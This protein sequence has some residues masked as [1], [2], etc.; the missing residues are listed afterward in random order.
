MAPDEAA[1]PIPDVA[2]LVDEMA[3][4]AIAADASA[5]IRC[6][7]P[8]AAAIIGAPAGDVIG[9][10]LVTLVPERFRAVH[11]PAFDRFAATGEGTIVGGPPVRVFL[12]RADGTEV[13]V[14]LALTAVGEPGRAGFAVV[15]AMRDVPGP[16]DLAPRPVLGRFLQTIVDASHDGVLALSTDLRILAVNARFTELWGLPA[17]SLRAG[18]RSPS[19]RQHALDLVAE[20][21]AFEAVLQR[22][23]EHPHETQAL[24]VVLADG[25]VLDGYA[26]PILDD[27]GTSFGRVWF[28]RDATARRAADAQRAALLEQLASAQRTQRFLLQ[29]SDALARAVG[30]A[31]TLQALAEVAVP[32]LGDLCLIDVADEHGGLVRM[33]AVHADPARRPLAEELRHYPPD[34]ASDHPSV[35]VMRDGT[36]RWSPTMT[37]DFLQATS[38]D[39][40][41]RHVMHEL[42][43]SGYMAVPLLAG[44][45]VL[46]SVTLVSAGSGRVLGPDDLA[47]AED[48]AARV[49]LVVA[50]ERRYDRERTTSHLLQAGLLPSLLPSPDGV[51]VA[52]RYLPGTVDAEVGGDFWDLATMPTGEVAV[53]VGDVA[54]HDMRAAAIMAQVRS[55]CRALRPQTSSPAELVTLLQRTW[56]HLAVDRIATAVFARLHPATGRLTIAS[57]GHPPPVVV[58]RSGARLP[59]LQVAPPLGAPPMPPATWTTTLPPGGAVVLYTDGLV[60]D[61]RRTIAEGLRLLVDAAASAP[62]SG[63]EAMADHLLTALSGEDRGDD[64]A[65]MVLRRLPR[66]GSA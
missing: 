35:L 8:A 62:P 44:R 20:P 1:A 9:Q 6:C 22:G 51:E 30:V 16:A 15:A 26:A 50:K 18:D 5:T 24:D 37:V 11:G 33:A 54:G 60:E 63:A 21:A 55:V 58:D 29:A 40:R 10:P 19:L 47:L 7:N 46:G 31:D 38:R 41:H 3:E 42:E 14:E 45:Q 27:R 32:T 23:R 57:A 66:A 49:A 12:R 53:A 64:V 52:V 61:R 39:E 59:D 56:D 34:P 28:L 4:A 25:R 48:L 17:G 2:R 13:D 65:L 36:S 43:F